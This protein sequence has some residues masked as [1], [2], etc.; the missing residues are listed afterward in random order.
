MARN[1]AKLFPQDYVLR[2]VLL[3][4]IP[5]FIKPNHV[6][7]L[8]LVLTPVVVY[9]LATNNLTFGVPLFIFTAFTDMVD[10]S[11]ARV[12]KEITPWGILFDPVAD[13]LLVGLVVL[14]FALRYYNW[15]VVLTAV[16]F[17]LLPLTIW[18]L[19]AKA[20]R[21]MMMANLWGKSKLFLQMASIGLLLLAILLRLPGLIIVGQI[22]LVIA[23]VLGAIAAVTYSL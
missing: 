18:L 17:D 23:T 12:R 7:A 19:R 21:A 10:G 14:V 2:A 8:R 6:T 15:M 9:L 3:P 1:P 4:F 16:A 13:K 20:N 11:L 5:D 22:V